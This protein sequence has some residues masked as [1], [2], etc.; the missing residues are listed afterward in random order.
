MAIASVG[1]C[2]TAATSGAGTSFTLTTTTNALSA[3]TDIAILVVVTDNVA[4]T[5]GA[6]NTHTSVTGGTGAWTKLGEYTNTVGGAA[7]DGCCTSLWKFRSTGTN[8]IG[9]VFTINHSSLSDRCASLWKFTVAS[10][11]DLNLSTSVV[12]NGVDGTTGF[13]S[14]SFSSLSSLS[15]LYIRGLGKEA[16][17]TTDITVSTSFS[18]LTL[19]RSRNNASAVLLRGEFRINTSTGETSNP[20]LAVSGDT[21]AVFA[22]LEEGAI[23]WTGTVQ[24]DTAITV[25]A[26]PTLW[27]LGSASPAMAFTVT[28]VA[29]TPAV[30]LAQ[31]LRLSRA[32][33][34]L[35]PIGIEARRR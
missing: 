32:F 23:I 31:R 8:A 7:A 6:S 2:G 14:A 16:N 20:T 29:Y 34:R 1:T 10:G 30:M 22:A 28:A 3:T 17:S 18:A 9:T 5:D 25:S 33:S 27:A 19:I 26:T 12:T 4:T 35:A 11:K 15:R 21:A 13:G 24:A